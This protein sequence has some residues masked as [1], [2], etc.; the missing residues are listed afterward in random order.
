MEI[1]G[2]GNVIELTREDEWHHVSDGHELWQESVLL[3]WWDLNNKLGGVHRI[4]H[5][6]FHRDGPKV[7]VWN[8]LFAPSCVYKRTEILPLRAKDTFVTGFGGGDDSFKFEFTDHAIWTF[9]QKEVSG[10]L[11]VHDFH[12]PVDIY[13]KMG[14][15]AEQIS[16]GHLEVGSSVSGSL[17]LNGK[18]YNVEG[19]AFRDHGWGRRDWNILLTHRWIGA[20]FGPDLSILANSTLLIGD[21]NYEFGCV[22]RDNK[23]IYTD[24]V[25]IV[26][27]LEH[28][29]LTHRGGHLH[30]ELTTGEI[31]DIELE[32]LQKGS[33]NWAADTMAITDTMCRMV[34][35][36]RIGICNFEISN[37]ATR[38]RHR[39]TFALNGFTENGL[40]LL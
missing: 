23:I 10:Q 19:M 27:Y 37:N 3:C 9:Q 21:V 13:P 22:M 40:H 7:H 31:L 35:G 36:D 25:D 38:G 2:G 5:Q 16:S 15:L 14:T 28:D 6:P 26:T 24:K 33:V 8:N 29:G 39:P 1:V 20:T 30:M 11:H 34:Y 18:H 32:V 4:G 12:T 17:T